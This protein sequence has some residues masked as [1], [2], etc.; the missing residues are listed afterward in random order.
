M[1]SPQPPA[2][3]DHLPALDGLRAIAVLMVLWFHVDQTALPS[4]SGQLVRALRP[5]YFGVD[6]FFVLSGF[7]ITRILLDYRQRGTPLSVFF[8]RRFLRIFP[9]YYLALGLMAI[10]APSWGLWLC[11]I[12]LANIPVPPLDV[13]PDAMGHLWS[14]SVEEHFYL[15]WPFLVAAAPRRIAGSL[16]NWLAPVLSIGSAAAFIL[17]LPSDWASGLVYENTLPRSLSLA[18]GGFLAMHEG[19]LRSRPPLTFLLGIAAAALGV[20][21]L[22]GGKLTPLGEWWVLLRLVAGSVVSTGVVLATLAAPPAWLL[23]KGLSLPALRHIGTIS[24]GLYLYHHPI[25]HYFGL[26]PNEEKAAA[27][28]PVEITLAIGLTY[29][30]AIASYHF[31]ERPFLRLK[32]VLAAPTNSKAAARQEQS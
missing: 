9:A 7:L 11:A 23:A 26:L 31:W 25:Y 21:A 18:A 19:V 17:F 15:V 28:T 20:A 27:P 32:D 29:A 24:Y 10:L 13:V 8:I 2:R 22:V 1:T 3:P 16:M 4:W 6:F 12:Y 30:V 14:L 5:G